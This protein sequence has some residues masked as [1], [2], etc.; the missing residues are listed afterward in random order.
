MAGVKNLQLGFDA[1]LG[2]ALGAS[3]QRHRGGHVNRVA[4]AKVQRAAVQGA[5]LGQ[6]FADKFAER[7]IGVG[8]GISNEL[9]TTIDLKVNDAAGKAKRNDSTFGQTINAMESRLLTRGPASTIPDMLQQIVRKMDQLLGK[10][11][12]QN[13]DKATIDAIKKKAQNQIEM[14]PV[15]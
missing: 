10:P 13:D 1:Q 12:L 11:G 14:V 3:A 6:Q 15:L 9:D 7:M 5:N 2:D 8:E 4:V